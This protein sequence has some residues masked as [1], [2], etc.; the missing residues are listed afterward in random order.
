MFVGQKHAGERWRD[1]LGF[2]DKQVIIDN[3]G[4]GRFPVGH[5]SVGV[6]TD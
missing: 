1:I 4:Y 3:L 6:W 5:R 2:E